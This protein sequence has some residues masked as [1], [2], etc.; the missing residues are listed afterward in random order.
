MGKGPACVR[1]DNELR[2]QAWGRGRLSS[3]LFAIPTRHLV[4]LGGRTGT[5]IPLPPPVPGRPPAK[6][7]HCA[8]CGR[9]VTNI[10]IA[11]DKPLCAADTRC[12]DRVLAALA[13]AVY[14]LTFLLLASTSLALAQQ[15]AIL[16]H[17]SSLPHVIVIVALPIHLSSNPTPHPPSSLSFLVRD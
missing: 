4:R 15:S 14:V 8:L 1:Q 12:A 3:S 13:P 5:S 16:A 2:K 7:V 17:S 10:V 9:S 11:F 6:L